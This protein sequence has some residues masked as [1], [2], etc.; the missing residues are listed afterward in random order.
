MLEREEH[1]SQRYHQKHFF[2]VNDLRED[3]DFLSGAIHER[4]VPGLKQ[5]PI[6]DKR[7][8][9][10]ILPPEIELQRKQYY[11][12]RLIALISVIGG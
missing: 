12:I 9:N 8:I 7:H 11:S 1:D 5:Y 2:S 10:L 3:V 6:P 4:D